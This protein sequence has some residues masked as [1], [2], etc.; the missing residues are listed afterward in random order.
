MKRPAIIVAGALALVLGIGLGVG[1]GYLAQNQGT[2]N[3][4]AASSPS[5]A[6]STEGSP[7]PGGASGSPGASP[8]VEPS[9]TPEPTA[10]PQP[11]PT[12]YPAPLTGRM[13]SRKV[14]NRHVIAMMIDDLWAARPQSGLSQA[15]IVWQAPAEGGIPRY[16]AL[17]QSRLPKSVGPVRSSRLYFI[18]WASEWRAVYAH[19]GGSPQA[20]ALLRSSK[21]RGSVVFNADQFRWGRYLYRVHF[22]S[23]PH[24]VYSDAAALTKLSAAVGAKPVK[25]QAPRWKFAPD[26]PL[27]ARPVGG[28]IIVPYQENRIVYNYDRKTNTYLRTVSVEGKQFDAGLKPRVRIAPK[29]VV[30]MIVRFVPLGDHKHRLDGQVTGSG[31]AWFSTNG[32][33]VKG[34]WRK[35]TFT[36]TTHIY[37][38]NGKEVVFTVGQTFVQVVPRGTVITVKNGKVPAPVVS[39]SPSASPSPTPAP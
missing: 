7:T 35:K 38:P 23:A 3:V 39:P 16:L 9:P 36:S 10:T 13:V 25:N 17:F 11:T 19:A 1:A 31:V 26:A 14:A 37:G 24:N 8:S 29:N 34:T 20:L 21:G 33:T 18:A 28:R 6:G 12:L 22:R 30:V 32:K 5:P 2:S 15:D 27:A 4:A